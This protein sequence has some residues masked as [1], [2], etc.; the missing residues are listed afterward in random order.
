MKLGVVRMTSVKGE[1][2]AGGRH[3]DIGGGYEA[4]GRQND[5]G[6]GYEAGGR[7]IY[8]A[9]RFCLF[10]CLI[11]AVYPVR[12]QG[13]EAFAAQAAGEPGAGRAGIVERATSALQSGDAP[14]AEAVARQGLQRWPRDPELLH[15]LGLAEFRLNKMQPAAGDLAEAQR[16]APGDAGISFD[17]GLVYMTVRQYQGAARQFERVLGERNNNNPAMTHILLGRAY[18]NSNR[19]RQAIEQFSAALKLNP[20]VPLGHYH[21]GFAYESLG[22]SAKALSE[23]QLEA[24]QTGDNPEVFYQYGHML[25]ETGSQRAA[26]AEFKKALALN[27]HHADSLY[28]L[29]KSLLLLGRTAEAIAALKHSVEVAPDSVNGHYQLARALAR[30]GDQE[31]AKAEMERFATLKKMQGQSGA[32]ATGLR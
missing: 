12:A 8:I 4:G 23:L 29:G 18:Q 28:D 26:V 21:L 14:A 13:A 22:E 19:T 15:L 3:I 17:L 20:K 27:P 16:L 9:K 10:A 11:F 6:G 30:S 2:E 25:A 32:S 31:G 24:S 7:H 5:I 1:Y